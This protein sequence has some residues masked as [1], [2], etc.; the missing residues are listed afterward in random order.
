[1]KLSSA[2]SSLARAK[3]ARVILEALAGGERDPRI[4]AGLAA[5]QVRAGRAGI[6]KALEGMRYGD[7]HGRLTRIHLD[8]IT[9]LE[10]VSLFN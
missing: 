10:Q 8:H 4:L 7:H 1:V 5:G 2:V 6:E 3:S 9:F